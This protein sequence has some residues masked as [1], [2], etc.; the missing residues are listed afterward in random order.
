M[1]QATDLAAIRAIITR[2][3][4]WDLFFSII[5]ILSLMVGVLTFTVLF[6]D[7]AI[8]GVPRLTS[9]FFT[10]FPSRRPENA[11]ILSA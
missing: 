9:E 1:L 8:Q 3:K 7:M 2:A 5:G 6:V 11:G 10:S 4:R